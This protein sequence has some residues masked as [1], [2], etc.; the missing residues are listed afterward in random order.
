MLRFM[1][2]H[3]DNWRPRYWG[4][5]AKYAIAA[6]SAFGP[7]PLSSDSLRSCGASR[8]AAVGLDQEHVVDLAAIFGP[9]PGKP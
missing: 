6:N 4:S 3:P 1:S 5:T 2:H 8:I 9:M 7:T